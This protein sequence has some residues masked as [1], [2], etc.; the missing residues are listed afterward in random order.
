MAI[1]AFLEAE[2]VAA[3]RK[4]ADADLSDFRVALMLGRLHV[5]CNCQQFEFADD[6]ATLGYCQRFNA[7]AWPFVPFWCSG[8]QASRAVVAPEYL[9]RPDRTD[10]RLS[11]R[12]QV[13]CG[14]SKS[15][16]SS[17]NGAPRS[18]EV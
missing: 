16:I 14:S 3:A 11:L 13:A 7:E 4:I 6:P 5:C 17:W 12:R 18:D 10:V 15:L 1:L 8:F 2:R 9:P